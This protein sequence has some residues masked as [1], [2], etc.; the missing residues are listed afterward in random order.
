MIKERLKELRKGL[1]LQQSEFGAAI[2][3]HTQTVSRYE[4]GEIAPGVEVLIKMHDVY[5]VSLDWLL[6][7][8][9]EMFGI[10]YAVDVVKVP[11]LGSD[12]LIT[13]DINWL[14]N[15]GIKSSSLSFIQVTNDS[16]TPTFHS[17][18]YVLID[19]SKQDITIDSIMAFNINN[20][21][22]IKRVGSVT[23][24]SLRLV[25][26][27]TIVKDIITTDYEVIGLA[28]WFGRAIS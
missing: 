26:D 12:K 8:K 27:N 3:T 16:M 19:S 22:L 24:E 23:K 18:D 9:G 10:G 2:G 15:Q 14:S 28:V 1:K 7:G 4:R 17:R 20:S 25:S 5:G 6:N 13:L 21:I 11:L